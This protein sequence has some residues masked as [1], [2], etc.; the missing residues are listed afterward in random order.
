MSL[1]KSKGKQK[2]LPKLKAILA[3]PDK[4][5]C[6]ILDES[7]LEHFKTLLK[8]AITESK[9][10]PR[11][12]A[13]QKGICLGLESSLRKINNQSSSSVFISLSIKPNYLVGLIARNAENKDET[14][15]VYA[16]PKLENVIEELFGIKAVCMVLPKNLEG[17]S[18]DLHNWIEKRKRP[19]KIKKEIIKEKETVKKKKIQKLKKVEPKKVKP[20]AE[21]KGE[22]KKP[23]EKSWSGDY[24]SF[25]NDNSSMQHKPILE[26]D[27][28][29]DAL[30]EIIEKIP[31]KDVKKPNLE[32]ENLETMEVDDVTNTKEESVL[33]EVG[34]SDNSDDFLGD[35]KA[36]TVHKIKGNPNKKPKKKRK[37]NKKKNQTK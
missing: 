12:F 28:A 11:K 13:T 19:S 8:T 29:V 30:S 24:I 7:E 17:I 6:P 20:E 14:Q 23:K 35:Y 25:G 10:E 33:D 1:N 36:L 9:L 5:K 31:V 34:D 22:E 32:T 27:E 2:P 3:N 26:G 21:L 18:Q 15:P 37:K 16:Q 4:T